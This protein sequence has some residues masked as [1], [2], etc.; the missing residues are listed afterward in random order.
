MNRLRI[1]TIALGAVL[2]LAAACGDDDGNP[3]NTA[4]NFTATLSGS[5]EVPPTGS[6][7]TGSATL[8]V[9]GQQIEYTVNVTGI[10][11]AVLAHIHIAPAGENG[12]V[13]LNLC[14][15]GAPLPACSS[16][17]GVLATGTNGNHVRLTRLGDADGWRLRQRPHQRAGLHPRRGRLQSGRRDPRAG[18]GRELRTGYKR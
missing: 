13:R 7:A 8:T 14:G 3:T 12:P 1:L 9:N 10:Q 18:R 11:N 4:T 5:N 6:T 17:T 2:P 16:G 15:T